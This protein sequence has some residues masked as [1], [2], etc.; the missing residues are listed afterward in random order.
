MRILCPA[1]MSRCCPVEVVLVSSRD[2]KVL[3]SQ[4][5]EVVPSRDE[6]LVYNRGK[7]RCCSEEMVSSR[8]E[9]VVSSRRDEVVSS[10]VKRW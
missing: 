5:G 8:I 6:E 3:Y 7:S 10:K 4:G 1:E 9:E 2:E